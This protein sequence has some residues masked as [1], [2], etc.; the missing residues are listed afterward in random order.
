VAAG[1]AL[2][3]VSG[4][5]ASDADDEFLAAREA[6]RVGDARKLDAAAARLRGHVLQP[7]VDYWQL[8]VRLDATDD[9]EIR[10]TLAR[11]G[12]TPAGD[13]LRSDWLKLVA[14]RGQWEVFDAEL[15]AVVTEDAELSCLALQRRYDLRDAEALRRA[16]A[17][18]LT[19][20]DSPEPC[21]AVFA[22]MRRSG[23]LGVED[24]WS[25]LRLALDAGQVTFAKRLI[26]QLPP[27]EGP[28]AKALDTASAN[29]QA[30]LD[31]KAFDP[32][33]RAGRETVVFALSRIARSSPQQAATRWRGLL[34]LFPEAER[35][36][37]WGLLAQ[38]AAMRHDPEALDWFARA[39]TLSDLQL[40]WKAR[41][42]L[43]VPQWAQV[44]EA[45]DAMS[46]RERADPAWQ[47]WK[48]RALK[49][50]GRAAEANALLAPLSTDH[51]FYGLLA[52]EALGAAIGAPA[53]TYRA[54]EAEVRAAGDIPGIRRALAFYRLGLRFEGN[55]EWFWTIRPMEDR[56]LLAVAELARR[57][58]LWDRAINTAERTRAVHDF[59]LRYLAPHRERFRTYAQ[60]HGLDEAWVL[61][62]VRQE[63]RFI[64][65]ARSS[66]G[67]RGLM[68]LMP[69]T[70]QW[71]AGRLGMKD[72][73]QA[74]VTDLDTNISLGT[75]YLRYVLDTLDN[76][77][78]LASA[79]YNAGPGRARAWRS[80]EAMEGAIYSET[81]PFNETRDYVKKVMANATYYAQMLGQGAV[82]L[83]QRIG[84]VPP[85]NRGQG[86]S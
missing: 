72:F 51:G 68:Q 54:S 25:R 47:Y 23:Q 45:I 63:S 46:D 58:E 5:W 3:A 22:A 80:E 36:Y 66:A 21:N 40:A 82:S 44:L 2:V 14:R 59:A 77:P 75:Y 52:T 38:Q 8:R 56:Q 70:A 15:P 62:L 27:R 30:Y 12:D 31:R 65:D 10:A 61:G 26:A 76:H 83:S 28:D 20:R 19:P 85:R 64:H 13:R 57:N 81:I 34:P 35:G 79:G 42:A 1:L 69:A 41:A 32:R 37:V 53:Q 7:W 9:D 86:G 78:V 6:F 48:A 67:A 60:E 71:V 55:R 18:W 11:L 24:V 50:Q 73:R 39:G 49:A 33:T 43:R 17:L 84:I 4:C 16:R 29:P 74:G